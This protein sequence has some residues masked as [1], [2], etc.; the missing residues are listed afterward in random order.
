MQGTGAAGDL[1]TALLLLV[2][3]TLSPL[4]SFATITVNANLLRHIHT[5]S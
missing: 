3:R 1:L 5:T 2:Y 4:E